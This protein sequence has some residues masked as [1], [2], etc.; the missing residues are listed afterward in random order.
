MLQSPVI[1]I[2][3]MVGHLRHGESFGEL[4]TVCP[5]H[6]QGGLELKL[7]GRLPLFVCLFC[8]VLL[9]GCLVFFLKTHLY[10]LYALDDYKTSQLIL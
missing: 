7:T 1:L 6:A 2:P 9:V 3:G 8:F 4:E 10:L 5:V